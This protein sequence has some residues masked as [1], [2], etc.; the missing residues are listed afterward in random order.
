M[1]AHLYLLADS[2]AHNSLYSLNEIELKVKNLF[3]DV[4]L[5]NTYRD[6]NKIYSNI[7]EL[8]NQVFYESYTIQDFVCNQYELRNKGIDRDVITALN[9]I[10]DISETTIITIEEVRDIMLSWNDENNS[11]GLLCFHRLDEINDSIQIIYGIDGWRKFRRIFLAKYPKKG[12]FFIEECG[13]YFNNIFFHER[14]KTSCEY[15]LNESS[16]KIVHYLSELNDKFN[17]SKTI[18]YSRIESLRRFNSS[19]SFDQ[20]ASDEGN[21]GSKNKSK[22][23]KR[24]SFGFFDLNGNKQ[25][26]CCDLH[27]KLLRDDKGKISTDRRIYFNEGN[28][29]IEDGKILVGHIGL[30]LES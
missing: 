6:T 12:D 3:E 19:C 7:N 28:N 4:R 5:I 2:F 16:S 10:L 8:Y 15:I 29:N 22:I 26:I 30:H 9:R 17:I 25:E 18:P 23:K 11:H 20:N 1:I 21:S 27:L 13:K 14:N 24:D